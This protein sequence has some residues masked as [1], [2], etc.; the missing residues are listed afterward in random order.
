MCPWRTVENMDEV[1]GEVDGLGEGYPAEGLLAEGGEPV[2]GLQAENVRETGEL[3]R[4]SVDIAASS[5]RPGLQFSLKG[6][7]S[8]ICGYHSLLEFHKL[9]PL[10]LCWGEFMVP[11]SQCS[12]LLVGSRTFLIHL[13]FRCLGAY[14]P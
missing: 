2:V 10:G 12:P 8:Y 1:E 14:R 7:M 13:D 11:H 3:V 4:V 9:N 6:I 5:P